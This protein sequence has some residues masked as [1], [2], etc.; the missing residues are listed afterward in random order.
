MQ[1]YKVMMLPRA[2]DDIVNNTDYIAFKKKAPETPLPNLSLC[3]NS[4]NL[5][6]MRNLLR[7]KLENV[8]LKIIRYTFLL[9]KELVR[10]MCFEFYIC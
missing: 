7:W 5:M 10:C 2:E 4:M 1:T 3:L 8:I 6:K 9:M